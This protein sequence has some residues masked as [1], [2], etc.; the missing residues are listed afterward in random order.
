MKKSGK[1]EE[2]SAVNY[3]NMLRHVVLERQICGQTYR[4]S[5]SSE[6]M[7]LRRKNE[8]ENNNKD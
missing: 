7:T 8:S 4:Y 5:D 3:K 6:K 1:I 2:S